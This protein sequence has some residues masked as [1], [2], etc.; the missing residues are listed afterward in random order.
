MLLGFI[1]CEYNPF[2]NGHLMQLQY[3]R[4]A[5]GCDKI[6]C[7]MSGN[8]VQRG[9]L[10]IVDKFSRASWAI[11][12]GADLVVE[13]PPQFCLG[14]AESFAQGA[15]SLIG[16]FA[17]EKLLCFGSECGDIKKLSQVAFIINQEFTQN[18]I[19]SFIKQG[20]NYPQSVTLAM[21]EYC[22]AYNL[23]QSLAQLL[24]NPNNTLA[25]EYLLAIERNKLDIQTNT[26]KRTNDYNG[27][28]VDCKIS[29]A[30]A[31]RNCLEQNKK[32]ATK[33]TVPNYV[34]DTLP[35][36]ITSSKLFAI[37]KFYLFNK[38]MSTIFGA[39][40][41]LDNRIKKTLAQSKNMQEFFSLVNTKRYPLA[42]IKRILLAAIVDYHNEPQIIKFETPT[43][44][45]VL[46][47][48]KA[49]LDLLGQTTLNCVTK[50]SDYE[51]FNLSDPL[52]DSVDN[53][54]EAVNYNFENH[55]RI[56]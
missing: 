23:D 20:N 1:I 8:A 19:K 45:N 17:G 15:I 29:S 28:A 44:L 21:S 2:H 26:I 33:H 42:T 48:K 24:T 36:E 50:S 31:I 3:T 46:A 10:A 38:D 13:I 14:S 43:Y 56:E 35:S 16:T 55:M 54:F 5:L 9:E 32:I 6:I 52:M 39:K 30:S 51:R 40:E 27:L 34:Y 18:K 53:L 4:N 37:A 11:K 49:S 25:I 22:T 7:V 41:G 47:V 12:G